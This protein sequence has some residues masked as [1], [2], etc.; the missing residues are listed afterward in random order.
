VA[1]GIARDLLSPDCV[2]FPGDFGFERTTRWTPAHHLDEV[3]RLS[4]AIDQHVLV[5]ARKCRVSS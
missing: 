1:H 5:G 4:R 3:V 2:E